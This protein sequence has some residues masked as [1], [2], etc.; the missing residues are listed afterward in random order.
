MLSW[1]VYI[2]AD[3]GVTGLCARRMNFIPRILAR[4]FYIAAKFLSNLQ[5]Q[6][7]KQTKSLHYIHLDMVKKHTP[8]LLD[9]MTIN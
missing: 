3:V 4:L 1:T 2:R 6:R 9:T 8:M 7:Q 5:F